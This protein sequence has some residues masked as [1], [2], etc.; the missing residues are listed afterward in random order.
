MRSFVKFF[1]SLDVSY[2]PR[3]TKIAT[4]NPAVTVS[5][6]TL[7]PSRPYKPSACSKIKR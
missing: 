2:V 1:D 5:S 4:E 7:I 6:S 3:S